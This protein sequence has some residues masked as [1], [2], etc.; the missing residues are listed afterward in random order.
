MSWRHMEWAPPF[1]TSARDCGKLSPSRSC[2]FT[3]RA[4]DTDPLW[5]EDSVGPTAVLN[6]LVKILLTWPGIEP[7]FLCRRACS[8]VGILNEPGW[9]WWWRNW[10]NDD[11]QGKPKYLEKTCPSALSTTNPTRS[12]WMRTRATAVV[13]QHLTASATARPT[14][15]ETLLLTILSR[16]GITYRRGLDFLTPYIFTQFGTTGNT[17]LLLICIFSI[18]SCTRTR[19]LPSLVVFWQ[20][21]YHSPSVSANHIWSFLCITPL[22]PLFCNCQFQRL[23]SIQFLCSRAHILAGWLLE[24]QLFSSWLRSILPNTS[25][26]H[27]GWTTQKTQPVLL[28]MRVYRAVLLAMDVILSLALAREGMCLMSSYLAMC[29]YVTISKW[30]PFK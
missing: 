20:R 19:F 3:L 18:Q 29:L 16:V 6:V 5:I 24:T 17:A 11:W 2:R 23:D 13:S 1:L 27:F 22:L 21:I 12:A 8:L 9:L 26:N 25:Y 4:M 7:W 10:W 28:T 15:H 14:G 30:R